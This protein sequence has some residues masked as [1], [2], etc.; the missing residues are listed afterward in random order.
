MMNIKKKFPLL[1]LCPILL[2]CGG[3]GMSNDTNSGENI[4]SEII[5]EDKEYVTDFNGITLEIDKALDYELDENVTNENGS[6]SYEIFVRS[7]YDTNGDGIGDLNGVKAKIPYL[8]NLGIK[9]V[10]LMPIMPSP[11]YHGYDTTDYYGIHPDYGTLDDFKAL[12]EEANKYHIDIMIDMVINHCSIKHDYFVQSAS[13]YI[14]GDTSED[15]KADWFNWGT[16]T[17]R[18]E[19]L[20]QYEGRFS[21]SMPDF[22][23]DSPG[24]RA[25]IDKIFK[26]WI[27]DMGVKGFR[28]DAVLYYYYSDTDKNVEF[29][30]FLVDTAKKYDENFYM[31][32][33]CWQSDGIV[34][35]YTKS[36]LD[37]FFRFG[38]ATGG[39]QA[40]T[41]ITKGY[42]RGNNYGETIEKNET[43]CKKNNP[44]YYSSY[45][46]SNHDQDRLATYYGKEGQEI[47]NKAA[48][49]LY[50]LMPGTP[51]MY[52]GEEILLKGK[53]GTTPD[54]MSDVKRRLPMIWSKDDKTGE[55]IFP[56]DNR[57]DLNDTIQVEEGVEDK[58]NENFSLLKHYQKVINVRNKYPLFKH[59]VFKNA[60]KEFDPEAD[61]VIAYKLT[62]GEDY[63]YVVHNLS[64]MAIEVNAV[65]TE[66]LD[67]INTSHL[68]PK[69]ENGKLSLAAHSTVIIK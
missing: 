40:F 23:L 42:G 1:L 16:G 29:M 35:L 45:F 26:F 18:Y 51:F 53:R 13:D 64:G 54:D 56:E 32:G 12:V 52:Y 3:T 61:A 49:S 33:E 27:Q 66:I 50:I 37:S 43:Y 65:G 14:N 46:L 63:I 68:K 5:S 11:T 60:Y 38:Q 58:L 31:V 6:M 47:Y 9:T 59:G 30:N 34:N 8:A 21:S 28:L 17:H 4:S 67:E 19:G 20:F 41:N 39:D 7:Y 55:C 25:E 15:S 36:K 57:Q 10:W 44:N 62:L 22:N 2:S 48:A 24:V 69:I